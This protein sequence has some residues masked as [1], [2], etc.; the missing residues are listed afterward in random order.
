MKSSKLP[1]RRVRSWQLSPK[2]QLVVEEHPEALSGAIGMFFRSG[3][4]HEP[5]ALQGAS[6]LTEHFVFKGTTKMSAEE[7]S[8][9][10]ERFG[11]DLNAYTDREVTCF[12][13]WVPR[14]Q[15]FLALDLL[16]EM[17]FDARL[18]K[19]DY[20]K[21][22][23]VVHQEIRGYEDSADDEFWDSLME[24]PWGDHPLGRRIGG[25]SSHVKGL[26]H[27]SILK[28]IQ[29]RFLS[30]PITVVV[31]SSLKAELIKAELERVLKRATEY[32]W[33]DQLRV[34]KKP[35]EGLRTP[36]FD[37]SFV[38]RSRL[39]SFDSDQVHL[40]FLWPSVKASHPSE[41]LWAA[42]TSLLG[43]G[44]SSK[45]FKEIRESLGL[46]YSASV[47][48]SNYSDTG[49][50]VGNITTDRK[51]W[52]EAARAAGN[53]FRKFA[54]GITQDELE[55]VRT[56]LE[57]SLYMNYEGVNNRME[58]LGRQQLMLGRIIGLKEAFAE[59]NRLKEHAKLNKIAA[60]FAKTPCFY[61]LGPVSQR[62][63]STLI[64][65]W[66]GNRK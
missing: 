40:G 66:E 4:R 6:H 12:H 63:L 26:T 1:E 48:L 59:L 56:M 32:L 52:L 43:I 16:F 45:L 25:F 50:V 58:S 51:R 22:R 42:A 17:I 7:I 41:I 8:E 53:V 29:E 30:A 57:G 11:G 31:V 61:A 36:K 20:V 24:T 47:S 3:S 38:K 28:H 13:A 64:A 14:N 55:F 21:E 65:T 37:R 33:A 15:V 23:E 46:A 44:S 9:R 35:A 10:I 2:I 18:D 62:D 5:L 19:E 49:L 34:C 54:T 27:Q 39:K 60:S